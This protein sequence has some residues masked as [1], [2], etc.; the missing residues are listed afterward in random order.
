M[1]DEQGIEHRGL[2]G[3]PDATLSRILLQRSVYFVPSNT[4]TNLDA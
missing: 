4:L 1:P 3:G 2:E